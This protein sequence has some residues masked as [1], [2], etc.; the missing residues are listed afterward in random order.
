MVRSDLPLPTSVRSPD[1]PTLLSFQ[2]QYKALASHILSP[3]LQSLYCKC[4]PVCIKC[5]QVTSELWR[6]HEWSPPECLIGNSLAHI[7]QNEGC[8]FL[9]LVNPSHV[10][11]FF[12]VSSF[13]PTIIVFSRESCLLIMWPN[14]NSLSSVILTSR[15]PTG[16]FEAAKKVWKKISCEFDVS[17]TLGGYSTW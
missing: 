7:F 9:N 16:L 1:I 10:G 6:H 14:Y 15:D 11:S 8:C 5:C 2:D 13:L 3:L 4:I 12:P 17:L